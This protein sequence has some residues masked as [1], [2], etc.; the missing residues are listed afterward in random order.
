MSSVARLLMVVFALWAGGAQAQQ[1][2][3]LARL[4]VS[5]SF[6]RDDGRS[7][8]A[9]DLHLTQAVPYRVF[10]LDQPRRLVVDFREVDWGGVKAAD[11]LSGKQAAGLRFGLFRPGWSRM[12][13]DLT[14]PMLVRQAGMVTDPETGEATVQL[15]LVATDEAGFAAAAGAPASALWDGPQIAKVPA[16]IRRRTGDKGPLV[17]VLDPGHGGIDPGAEQDGRSEADLVLTFA[18]ELKEV[19]TRAGGFKVLMTREEDVFVPL[20]TRISIARAAGADVFISLHA[21]TLSEGR[22]SGATVYTLSETASDEASAKLAERHD[23]GDL[24]AG[25]DLAGQDDVIAT[26]LMDLVRQETAPRAGKLADQ[27]V[28]SL[29]Q[30]IGRMHKRP[31]QSAGFSVLKAPD[32]PSVLIELGFLSST[33]DFQNLTSKEW[34]LQVAEGI[35]AGLREW[36]KQDA[37]E[38][39]LL[40]Q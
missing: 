21:D 29:K 37:A 39:R 17:V 34:R 23:R 24:L 13:V 12:V 22:A 1:M 27:L 26:V 10:T 15:R 25:V 5:R 33:Q 2:S 32:I 28:I 36:A 30:A 38:A 4:D 35:R 9:I 16:P 18:R 3:A 14:K 11:L 6:V 40:R 31:R 7:G 8:L 19:L 20:E